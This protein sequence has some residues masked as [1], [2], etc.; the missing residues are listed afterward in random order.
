MNTHL[1][2]LL[3]LSF[4]AYS[5][6]TI[7]EEKASRAFS[8]FN[9]VKFK[10]SA[11]QAATDTDLQGVCYT[12][13]E[14]SDNG[15]TTDGNCA[16]SFGVCCILKASTC[17]SSVTQNCSYIE[18]VGFPTART[19]TGA[20]AYT[21]TR[22][23]SEICQIRL[24]MKNMVIAQPTAA[25]GLC[26]DT[27]VVVAGAGTGT[28]ITPPTMCGTNTGQHIYIDAGTVSTAATLTFTTATAST[29]TWRVKVS[30]IACSSENKAPAG[31]LQYF[32]GNAGTIKSFN[33]LDGSGDCSSTG[34]C[35][36]QSQ[37]YYACIRKEEG[38]CS[39]QYVPSQLT[40]ATK[41]AFE[42]TVTIATALVDMDNCVTAATGNGFLE[43]PNVRLTVNAND[44][45]G[46]I[47]CGTALSIPLAIP[48]ITISAGVVSDAPRFNIR[49]VAETAAQNSLAGFSLDYGQMPC[50]S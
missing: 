33:W 11:C 44:I 35:W 8:L 19:D 24:D 50:T 32:T 45:A 5:H 21:V 38:M 20:C 1:L 48:A 31:C 26:V 39:I 9:V 34:G 43:I 42:L 13:E 2:L 6:S 14:C 40:D 23:S 17:G 30:Q 16:A 27:F 46:G 37:D 7:T 25:T 28:R 47:Y 36:T 18:N 10:N 22:C 4:T 15:G 41:D 49:V 29:A 3:L 12:S